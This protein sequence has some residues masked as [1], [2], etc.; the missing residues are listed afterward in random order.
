MPTILKSTTSTLG[1]TQLREIDEHLYSPDEIKAF[2]MDEAISEHPLK[3][4]P[5]NIRSKLAYR[6]LMNNAKTTTKYLLQYSIIQSQNIKKNLNI[7]TK[8]HLCYI[9]V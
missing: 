3:H 8:H 7:M 9:L 6:E 1:K 2:R 4:R 5:T